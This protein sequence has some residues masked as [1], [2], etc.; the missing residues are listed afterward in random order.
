M[1][2]ELIASSVVIPYLSDE[3]TTDLAGRLAARLAPGGVLACVEQDWHSDAL[4]FPRFD[5]LRRILNKEARNMK[6]T[7][8][9]GLRPALRRAGLSLL[10]R[11]SFLWTDDAYGAYTRDLLE[12]FAVSAVA[13]GR[14]TPEEQEEWLQT[15]EDLAREGDFYY[16]IVYHLVAG[17]S[18]SPSA[19]RWGGRRSGAAQGGVP[20]DRA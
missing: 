5:L 2:F 18:P 13:Q 3:Q 20:M 1:Q 7:L 6:P 19:L 15:L 17:F 14:I 10:P 12:R 11:V 8:A 16:G 9:L 4:V